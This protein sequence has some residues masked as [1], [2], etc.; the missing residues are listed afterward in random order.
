MKTT[1]RI[2]DSKAK[3]GAIHRK[4]VTDLRMQRVESARRRKIRSDIK[5]KNLEKTLGMPS[6][7]LLYPDGT[8]PDPDERFEQ[9]L[10][11]YKELYAGPPVRKHIPDRNETIL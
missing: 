7:T 9:V 10:A 11:K 3:D 8:V 5:M 2:I 6:G 4:V 1:K